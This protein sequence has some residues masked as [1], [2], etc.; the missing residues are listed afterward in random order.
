MEILTR[1]LQSIQ[2]VDRGARFEQGFR[3]H[4]AEASR[5]ARDEHDAVGQVELGQAFRRAQIRG[6]SVAILEGRGFLSRRGWWATP[7][8]WQ[9]P[10][11]WAVDVVFQPALQEGDNA[12]EGV[13]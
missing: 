12:C 11:R 2:G 6:G 3:L 9:G 5:R 7:G 8:D 10:F 1:L 13:C 4:E